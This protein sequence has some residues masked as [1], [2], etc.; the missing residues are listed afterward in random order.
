MMDVKGNYDGGWAW[1]RGVVLLVFAVVGALGSSPVAANGS[2]ELELVASGLPE[3]IRAS[4]VIHGSGFE[5]R[6]LRFSR[7]RIVRLP[8]GRYSVRVKR[9]VVTGTGRGVRAGAVAYPDRSRVHTLVKRNG[10]NE[11]EVAYRAVVNPRVQ[12]LPSGIV[13]VIGDRADPSGVVLGAG[14][15]PPAADTIY[16]AA[17]SMLLPRGLISK[18]VGVTRT[19]AGLLVSL[20]AVP[21]TR[22][23]PSLDY[24]GSIRLEPLGGGASSSRSLLSLLE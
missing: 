9:V 6:A 4:V 23:V 14:V 5:D 22:A 7:V 24:Q 16:A 11:V 21:V 2:T 18:V 3:N 20:K 1:M 10:Q 17:P 8:P 15:R 12:P 13:Q 19:R